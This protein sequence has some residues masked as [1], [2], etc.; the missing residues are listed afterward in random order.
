[1]SE[2]EPDDELNVEIEDL[3]AQERVEAS[4]LLRADRC[5]RPARSSAGWA[6]S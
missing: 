2:F 4:G 6:A 1:M 3:R 5:S